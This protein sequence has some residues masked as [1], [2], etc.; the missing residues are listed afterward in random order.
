[1]CGCKNP[2]APAGKPA[3]AFHL[4]RDIDAARFPARAAVAS[5]ARPLTESCM[6]R[7][8]D[9]ATKLDAGRRHLLRAA[10][11]CAIASAIPPVIA[12]ASR[13]LRWGIVGTG[14]IA[15]GMA[16]MMKLAAGNELAAVA[17]RKIETA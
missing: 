2:Q 15:N 4:A 9:D 7:Q 8:H 11:A 17:S 1:M 12:A 13:P 5:A 10:G 6:T 3:G 14:S 16:S